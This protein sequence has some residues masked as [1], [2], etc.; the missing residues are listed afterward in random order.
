MTKLLKERIK[1][2]IETKRNENQVKMS[3]ENVRKK[4]KMCRRGT[5]VR[6]C[7]QSRQRE[8]TEMG[9]TRSKMAGD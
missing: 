7:K 1:G 9:E 3:M 5:Q 6:K 2:K 8:E 4:N